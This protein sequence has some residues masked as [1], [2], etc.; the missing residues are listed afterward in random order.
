MLME[1]YQFGGTPKLDCIDGLFTI[2]TLFNM[3]NNHNLLI[4]VAFVDIVKDLDTAGHELMIKVLETYR[5][6]K[7]IIFCS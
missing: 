5:A 2:K 4:F 6:P 3:I 1:K 7:Q